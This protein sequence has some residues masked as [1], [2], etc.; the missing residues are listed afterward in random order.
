MTASE[1][2]DVAAEHRPDAMLSGDKH[3]DA[4][5]KPAP[6]PQK[7]H[8]QAAAPPGG[9]PI[10]WKWWLLAAVLSLALWA[11]IFAWVL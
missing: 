9:R 6:S 4:G 7:S 8:W 1:P 10:I 3:H 11:G 5:A 2:G